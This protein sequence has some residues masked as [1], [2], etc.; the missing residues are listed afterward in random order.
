MSEPWRWGS[1]FSIDTDAV[2]LTRTGGL[3][4]RRLSATG[5]WQLPWYSPIGDR[6]ELQLSLRGD[7]YQTDG[8]PQTFEENGSG[9][10]ARAIPR[11][12][13]HWSWP[14]I[15]ELFGLSQVIEPVAMASWAPTGNNDDNIP[16]EDS[17]DFEFD[18]TSLLEPNRFPG[19][20]RVQGGANFAYGV[21]FGTYTQTGLISGLLGQAYTSTRTLNS[22]RARAWTP[23]CPTMSVA[24]TSRPA[25]GW[26]RAIGFVSIGRTSS[27]SQRGRG[28]LRPA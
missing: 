18:D 9:I 28:E 3:D 20:D 24:S 1:R 27:S 4:T 26:T 15:G 10:Q 19:L 7:F 14:F 11:A 12:T 2:A 13:V 8:D 5:G 25:H 22:T 21:R 6:Y 17:Q 23:S 16:N